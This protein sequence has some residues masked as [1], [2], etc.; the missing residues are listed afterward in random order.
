MISP[1]PT[2]PRNAGHRERIYQLLRQMQAF[3]YDVHLLHVTLEPCGDLDAMREC[4]GDRL[5]VFQHEPLRTPNH[6]APSFHATRTG[7]VIRRLGAFLKKTI[8]FPY[9]VDDWHDPACEPIISELHR[10]FAFDVV[11]AEYVF[12]S[13]TLNLFGAQTL[14]ILDTHDIF[15]NRHKIFQRHR[16][17]PVWFYTTRREERKAVRRADV[18]LAIQEHERR[19]F[20]QLAPEKESVTVGHFVE[21]HRLPLKQDDELTLLFFAS[22]NPTNL[23]GFEVFLRESWPQIQARVPAVTLLIAGSVCAALPDSAAY[24]KLGAVGAAQDAYSLADVVIS[25]ILFGTGLKIKNVEALGYAKPLVTTPAGAE[26]LEHGQQTAFWAA[27]MPDDFAR[28][29]GDLLTDPTLRR[30]MCKQA[31]QFAAAIQ[32]QNLRRLAEALQCA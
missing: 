32:Q 9:R 13:K 14:K 25:P 15:G 12:C 21:L 28:R 23:H 31:Y 16:Q 17:Q 29:V 19:F 26:G 10:R 30:K 20:Q 27:Q 18:I 5:H 7:R 8:D 3:G 1:I 4:W 24:A 2:H 6:C 11:C 22:S